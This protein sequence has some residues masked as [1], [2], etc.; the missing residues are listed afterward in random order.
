MLLGLVLN[1]AMLGASDGCSEHDIKG[2]I[3]TY[4]AALP[5]EVKAR[6]DT[7]QCQRGLDALEGMVRCTDREPDTAGHYA[8]RVRLLNR[9][10][11][12]YPE[13]DRRELTARR[14]SEAKLLAKY[15]GAKRRIDL[16]EKL[17]LALRKTGG[18]DLGDPWSTH[19]KTFFGSAVLT[20]A[21]LIPTVIFAA[22]RADYKEQAMATTDHHD[23]LAQANDRY[24]RAHWTTVGFGTAAALAGLTFATCAGRFLIC[25]DDIS[26]A[27]GPQGVVVQGTFWGP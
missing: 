20:V 22:T 18:G 7:F 5:L 12:K 1:L 6:A 25:R 11:L 2:Y 8:A 27:P 17:D 23:N 19:P 4:D 9:L 15:A 24:E 3:A 10:V 26:I 16:E 13:C 14:W 21:L